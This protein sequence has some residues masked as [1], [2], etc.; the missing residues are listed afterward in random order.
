VVDLHRLA[1]D[2]GRSATTSSACHVGGSN[3]VWLSTETVADARFVHI[4]P[5]TVA[6]TARESRDGQPLG[7]SSTTF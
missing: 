7:R 6:A 4:D 5:A 3:N 2:G 1:P